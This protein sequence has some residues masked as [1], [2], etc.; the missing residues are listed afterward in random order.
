MSHDLVNEG[1]NLKRLKKIVKIT[2]DHCLEVSTHSLPSCFR[3]REKHEVC[4][5]H[6]ETEPDYMKQ[7]FHVTTVCIRKYSKY[8]PNF[9]LTC[10]IG[11]G[12]P[13]YNFK[14]VLQSFEK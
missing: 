8:F 11:D 7:S 1:E 9:C 3:R 2:A 12:L 5:V 6:Y 14:F 13:P 10:R 4:G